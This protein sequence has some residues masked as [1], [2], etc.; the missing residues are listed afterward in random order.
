MLSRKYKSS[1][2]RKVRPLSQ[3]LHSRGVTAA[4]LTAAGLVF[5]L[6]SALFYSRGIFG[7]GGLFLLLAG[8]CDALD[9]TV[10]RSAGEATPFGCFIDSVADRY[11]ELLVFGGLTFAYAGTPIL[12]LVLLSLA[13]SLMVS[14]TKAKAESLIGQCEVGF[15]ERPERLILLIAASFFG[16]MI[17]A[18]WILA[19]LTNA[20][21][22]HRI[23]YT[24][25]TIRSKNG[26]SP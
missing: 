1:F 21:A 3:A 12:A 25:K 11:S 14:Y 19:V 26:V 20:T 2:G 15:M 5:S 8:T 17:P 22:L 7:T 13:G 9:G 16:F 6:I 18:L 4:H 23:Y 24:W 10:A